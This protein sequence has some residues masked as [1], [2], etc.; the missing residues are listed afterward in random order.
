MRQKE[1]GFVEHYRRSGTARARDDT[2][3]RNYGLDD[4][5][6]T[7]L[8]SCRSY[9]ISKYCGAKTGD[10]GIEGIVR[11]D[12]KIVGVAVV[13]EGRSEEHTSELQSR[14]HLVCRL[15]PEK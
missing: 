4:G 8:E 3:R 11:A 1:V 5:G 7:I 10:C 12:R 6:K 2:I 14:L 9:A 15:L 13:W